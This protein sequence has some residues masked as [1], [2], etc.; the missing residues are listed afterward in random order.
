MPVPNF[1]ELTVNTLLYRGSMTKQ[2]S[3]QM[4]VMSEPNKVVENQA[5]GQIKITD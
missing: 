4:A 5:T 1:M 3:Q 2:N